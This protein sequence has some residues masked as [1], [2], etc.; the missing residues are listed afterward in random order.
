MITSAELRRL[1]G[2]AMK[3]DPCRS[4][5]SAEYADCSLDDFFRASA[6]LIENE[7]M[8]PVGDGA[9]LGVLCNGVRIARE[10]S[11]VFEYHEEARLIVNNALAIADTIDECE[12]LRAENARLKTTVDV[13]IVECGCHYGKIWGGMKWQH[14]IT[15]CKTHNPNGILQRLALAERLAGY[16]DAHHR[17]S[18][19][20]CPVCTILADWRAGK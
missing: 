20:D 2:K 10:L 5:V 3:D 15:W 8:N 19:W 9:T 17:H 7:S 13:D 16:L 1:A 6:V 12:R 18:N 4:V 14:W 11:R